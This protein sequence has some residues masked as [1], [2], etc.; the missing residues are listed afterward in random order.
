VKHNGEVLPHAL[1]GGIV[2]GMNASSSYL[3][4]NNRD[5]AGKLAAQLL[6]EGYRV[7]I[8]AEP[9]QTGCDH[10]AARHVHR[11]CV[12]QRCDA[13]RRASMRSRRKPAWRCAA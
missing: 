2:E 3:W 1:A 10:M 4:K 12:A 13:W 7:S 5:G 11:A 9:L 8:A 6:Q